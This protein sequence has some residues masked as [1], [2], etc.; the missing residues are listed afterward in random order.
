MKRRIKKINFLKVQPARSAKMYPIHTFLQCKPNPPH[1]LIFMSH[2]F[3]IDKKLPQNFARPIHTLGSRLIAPV[4][5]HWING[6]VLKVK[7]LGGTTEQHKTVKLVVKEWENNCNIAFNF[8]DTLPADIRI[9]FNPDDGAWSYVGTDNKYIPQNEPTMNLGWLD[10]GVIL[11]EFGHALGFA[12]E[13]QNPE[14]GI[15]WNEQVVIDELSGSP[16]FWDEW[17]IRH[18]VL[19]KYTFNQI[20]GTKFDVASIM[21]YLV[22]ARWTLNGIATKENHILSYEDKRF[23]SI[24]YPRSI[25]PPIELSTNRWFRTKAYIEKLGQEDLYTFEVENTNYFRI[26]TVSHMDTSIRLYGPDSVDR[27][28][29]EDDNSGVRKNSQIIKELGTGQYWVQVRI[30]DI[31][32]YSI[33]VNQVRFPVFNQIYR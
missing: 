20:R 9:T 17:T 32:N 28:I 4:S 3:C 15:Q 2:K 19:D 33:K 25:S 8:V 29:A 10:T 22:P 27:L 6:S 18:N 21:L 31:G 26:N 24:F 12:H 7:F 1:P 30:N 11:H 14:G 13:H 23:A 16:N 5:K